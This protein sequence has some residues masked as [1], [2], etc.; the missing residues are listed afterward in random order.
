[1]WI[2]LKLDSQSGRFQC[3]DQS[4]HLQHFAIITKL[5]LIWSLCDCNLMRCGAICTYLQFAHALLNPGSLWYHSFTKCRH[6]LSIFCPSSYRITF[7]TQMNQRRAR[8]IHFPSAILRP[9]EQLPYPTSCTS[10]RIKSVNCCQNTKAPSSSQF[11][12]Q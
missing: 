5:K 7:R 1:M 4:A 9:N 3:F 12:P 2:C 8:L 6:V 11:V 10:A